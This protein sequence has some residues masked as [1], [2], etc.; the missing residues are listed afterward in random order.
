MT[1]NP[2]PS[3]TKTLHSIVRVQSTMTQ[4]NYYMIITIIPK[5]FSPLRLTAYQQTAALI[6]YFFAEVKVSGVT[7]GQQVEFPSCCWRCTPVLWLQSSARQCLQLCIKLAALMTM[8]FVEN[9]KMNPHN[10][11][12]KWR[13]RQYS[14]IYLA[15]DGIIRR[16]EKG[17]QHRN[18]KSN[19]SFLL[20]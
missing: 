2:S 5:L 11:I 19:A 9:N 13:W 6:F 3:G 16:T 17:G 10:L 7:Y 14:F 15:Q 8:Y 18:L 4:S 1:E 12:Q 20:L